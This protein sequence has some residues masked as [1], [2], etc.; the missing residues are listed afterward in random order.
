MLEHKDKRWILIHI[1]MKM[2]QDE[3]KQIEN[4]LKEEGLNIYICKGEM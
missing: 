2:S 1:S 3:I 4:K